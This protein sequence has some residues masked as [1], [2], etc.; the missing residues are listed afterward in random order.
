MTKAVRLFSSLLSLALLQT[1]T[2]AQT[3]AGGNAGVEQGIAVRQALDAAR[4][5]PP[6]QP[7]VHGAFSAGTTFVAPSELDDAGMI[8]VER[9][10]AGAGVEFVATNGIM[11]GFVVDRERSR[12]DFPGD[13]PAGMAALGNVAATRF[14]ANLRRPL[15]KARALRQIRATLELESRGEEVWRQPL[16]RVAL[17]VSPCLQ[18]SGWQIFRWTDEAEA[19]GGSAHALS[20]SAPPVSDGADNAGTHFLSIGYIMPAI[21]C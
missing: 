9:G 13:S 15:V 8:S 6:I 7:G 12:Y 20:A 3:P 10:S 18:R 5:G 14:G 19:P 1:S 17:S 4:R 2:F 16:L 21:S 11:F